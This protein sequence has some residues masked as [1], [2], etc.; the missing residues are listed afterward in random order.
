MEKR[1][2]KNIFRSS[3]RSGDVVS[4]GGRASSVVMRKCMVDSVLY[5]A[6]D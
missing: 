1:E 4:T 2:T 5:A 3:F 6:H